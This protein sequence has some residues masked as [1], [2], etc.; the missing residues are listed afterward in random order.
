MP[1]VD[2]LSVYL[3]AL[4]HAC[5]RPLDL[6][7]HYWRQNKKCAYSGDYNDDHR[8][9]F[10][11]PLTHLSGLTLRLSSQAGEGVR[12]GFEEWGEEERKKIEQKFIKRRSAARGRGEAECPDMIN[13]PP[14]TRWKAP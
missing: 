10:W 13:M 14:P 6:E 1:I 7:I 4:C 8:G 2:T 12:A 5:A 11:V 3:C 9:P